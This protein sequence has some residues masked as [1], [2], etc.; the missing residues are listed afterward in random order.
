M[1][2]IN[3]LAV[4]AMFFLCGMISFVTNLAAPIGNVWKYAMEGSNTAGMMGNMMNFL[5]YLVA[6]VP[7]GMLL[8]RIGYKKTSLVAIATGFTGVLIQFLS[9]KA[10]ANGFTVYLTG[11]FVA[12]ISMCLLNVVTNPMLNTLGGGGKRGNQLN[13][14]GMTFNSI[15]GTL[16]PLL[17]GMLIGEISKDTKMADVNLVLY[18]ALAVFAA[19]FFVLSFLN[20]QDPE[21]VKTDEKIPVFAPLKF[22][23]CLFGVIG[24][25]CYVGVEV[26]IPATMNLW[27]SATDG[28]LATAGVPGYV[29]IAGCVA[30]TYWMMMIIGRTI[31]SAIGAKV[32]SRT[33]LMAAEGTAVILVILG[34]CSSSVMVKFPVFDGAKF[35]FTMQSIPLSAVFFVLCGLCTSVGFPCTFNLAVEGLGKYTNAATGLFMAMIVGGGLLPLAQGA[36][37][38]A[39]GFMPAFIIP[40]AGFAYLFIYAAFLSRPT[41][42]PE[43]K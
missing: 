19:T 6:G 16:T 4:V 25:F 17:V 30:A 11:A 29:G 26:G 20:I 22:R 38:D 39:A 27:L 33:M 10:G 3:Y 8:S 2:K 5:A 15:T 28:P 42:T 1:K 34:M 37:A 7:S 21:A 40:V 35:A 18:I 36:V 9:G 13:M 24:I 32:S 14:I 31:G 41:R 12:G 43:A 23:H